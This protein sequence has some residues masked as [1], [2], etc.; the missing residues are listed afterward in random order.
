[1]ECLPYR[2]TAAC[3]HGRLIGRLP[4]PVDDD[5]LIAERGAE[6]GVLFAVD[7]DVG[8][9]VIAASDFLPPVTKTGPLAGHAAADNGDEAPAGL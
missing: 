3:D 7:A 8:P 1:M 2:Q 6:A 4:I 9:H 5:D